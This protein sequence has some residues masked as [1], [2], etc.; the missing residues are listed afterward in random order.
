MPLTKPLKLSLWP[1]K[2]LSRF[3][4]RYFKSQAWKKNPKKSKFG[5]FIV[6]YLLL[7]IFALFYSV[8]PWHIF[9]ILLTSFNRMTE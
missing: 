2:K 4:V 5:S 6:A 8:I 9:R 7:R 3:K 1:T